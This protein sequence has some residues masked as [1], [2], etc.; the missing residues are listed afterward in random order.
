MTAPPVTP[1]VSLRSLTYAYR[2][3]RRAETVLHGVSLDVAPGEFVTVVGPSGSGKS[4][5]LHVLALLD[6]AASGTYRFDGR[7]VGAMSDRERAALAREA[8]AVVFQAYHLL[9]DL[10]VAENVAEPL[11]YQKVPAAERTRR[12]AE[13]LARFGLD[14]KADRYPAELSGGQQQLVGVARA[15][16]GRPRLLLADEPTGNLHAAQG[17]A[18]VD[19][20]RELNERDGVTVLH[21]THSERWAAAGGRVVELLDGRVVA[22][23]ST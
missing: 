7:D 4:T 9:D 23:S 2:T 1:L 6:R 3:R 8:V 12:V 10:T 13:V 15:L 14:A 22:D 18:V 16:A 5:L 19:A 17:G 11:R 21:V 20:L